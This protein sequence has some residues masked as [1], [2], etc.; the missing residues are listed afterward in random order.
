VLDGWHRICKAFIQGID[1]IDAVRLPTMPR[2]RWR[3][4]ANGQEVE[5][6]EGSEEGGTAA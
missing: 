1:G 6:A 5:I 2:Y 3:V 4:L